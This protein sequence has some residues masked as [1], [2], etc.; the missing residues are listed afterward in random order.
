[1]NLNPFKK[2][3]KKIKN[4]RRGFSFMEVMITL[5]LFLLLAGVGVGAYFKYYKF[6]LINVDINQALTHIKQARFRALKNPE[7]ANYGVHLDVPCRCLVTYKNTYSPVDSQN[8]TLPLRELEITN[9]NLTPTIGVTSDIL[10][11]KQTGKTD[12]VGSFTLS[13]QVYSYTFT[14]NAQGVV[15]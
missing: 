12:N 10:F 15:D 11:K 1:M 6:S 2:S 3:L 4:S 5:S 8:I 14:I 13:N 7:N 9:I